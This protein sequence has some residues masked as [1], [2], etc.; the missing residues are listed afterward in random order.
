M[1][2]F[3]IA[4]ASLNQTPLDWTGNTERMKCAL[5]NLARLS[6]DRR[7]EIIL[8]PELSLTGY[9][10]DDAFHSPDV[11]VRALAKLSELSQRAADLLPESVCIFGLPYRHQ[12]RIYNCAAVVYKGRIRGL[13]P[14]CNLAGEGV[15]Y[16]QR[17]FS[18]GTPGHLT[19]I[20]PLLDGSEI[21]FGTMLFEFRG[22]RFCLEICEDAWVPLRPALNFLESGLNLI[23]NPAASH[24]AF[25]KHDI[26]RQIARESSRNFGVLFVTVNLLGCEAGRIIYD[27]GAILASNGRIIGETPRFSFQDMILSLDTHDLTENN[28][29][30]GRLFSAREP[31]DTTIKSSSQNLMVKLEHSILPEAAG[32]RR[33]TPPSE[34]SETEFAWQ[35]GFRVSSREE[36]FIHATALGLFDYLRKSSAS[37]FV[38]SLSGGADSTTCALLIQRMV[39]HAL[40]ELGPEGALRR[41]GLS[42]QL[43]AIHLQS[44][45]SVAEQTR[46]ILPALLHTLY[47]GLENSSATTREAAGSV[48]R[49]LGSDHHEINLQE[50]NDLYTGNVERLLG[51]TL[52]WQSDDLS[53]QNIQARVRGPMAWYLAN[54]TGSLLIT[55]SNRS[56]AAVG[57]CTMDGDTCGGLAPIAGVDKAFIRR[58]LVFMERE[59][60][61]TAE[62][63]PELAAI[64]EQDPTAEL[65]PPL[66][67]QTDETDLM[68][69]D[70]LDRIERL[71]IRDRRSPLEIFE[72]L[73]ADPD[74]SDYRDILVTSIDRFFRLWARNQ[75]KRE[76]YA[77][78]F[79]L[80]DESLDPRT[81]YRFPILNGGYSE[82]L[83]DLKDR[84]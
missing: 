68:P 36:E 55:T 83:D 28:V 58:W 43:A 24:F 49:A 14:K 72:L 54:T 13:V 84:T 45:Q 31:A 74:C 69:Y 79:H 1:Q 57:Y 6:P 53:L 2:P 77:P 25:G 19:A 63:L 48:A 5:E 26:R 20:D 30:R 29:F 21:P 23:L 81:W 59:G 82:E 41:L 8:F 38:V 32:V 33:A 15:H 75:W 61:P 34:I 39:F 60:E 22:A 46:R 18:P 70:L 67:G 35:G 78:S 17:W 71:A 51:R 11:G 80:D 52:N 7:P 62:P 27:G 73:K 44:D 47:Q 4:T 37:G 65:R 50:I 64:N 42:H 3:R 40:Q 76:R 66:S 10:C 12:D 9:G 56:E 16:E